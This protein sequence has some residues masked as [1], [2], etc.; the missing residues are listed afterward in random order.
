MKHLLIFR[1]P[2]VRVLEI[3][4]KEVKY[5]RLGFTEKPG[6]LQSMGSQSRTQLSNFLSLFTFMALR[7]AEESKCRKAGSQGQR[8]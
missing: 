4:Q 1:L 6:R 3:E 7:K 8:E 2:I 5:V